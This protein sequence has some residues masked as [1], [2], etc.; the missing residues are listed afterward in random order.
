VVLAVSLGGVIYD[1]VRKER[2]I[3]RLG[4]EKLSLPPEKAVKT[5]IISPYRKPM[6]GGDG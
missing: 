5:G 2:L 6:N 1:N 3:E 4:S